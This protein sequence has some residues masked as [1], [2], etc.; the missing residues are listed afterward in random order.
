MI[1]VNPDCY[2]GFRFPSLGMLSIAAVLRD[3]DLP[4]HYVDCNFEPDWK[5]RLA[6][7]VAE[8]P[9]IGITANILSIKP[10]LELSAYIRGAHPCA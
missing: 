1:F 2:H 10:A 6:S 8:D 5:T 7:L 3:Q 9:L 4:A